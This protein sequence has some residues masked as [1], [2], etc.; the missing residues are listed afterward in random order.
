MLYS[1]VQAVA[2]AATSLIVEPPWK[3]RKPNPPPQSF[4]SLPDVI[5]LNCLARVSMS[6]YPKLSLVSKTFHSLILSIE[7]NH[8]RFH[9]Q[10]QEEIFSICLQFHD[11]PIPTWYTLWIK[12]G[13]QEN[14]RS[15]FVQV[16]SSY[17]SYGPLYICT[18]GSDKY[19]LRQSYPP[20][21][22]MLVRNKER[23]EWR[24]SP[25]MTVP[26]AY[27]AACELDGKIYVMGGCNDGNKSVKE[28]CWGEVFD[29]NTQTWEPLPNP[30]A[31]L[32]FSSVIKNIEISEGKLYVRSNE[33]KDSVYDPIKR[34][35]NVAEKKVEGES[36]CKV[37]DIHYSC[38]RK[39]CMWYDTESDEWRPV[40]GLSS[41]N[42][43][44]RRGLIETGEYCGKLLII[45]DK[46]ALPRRNLQKSICCALVSFEN[47]QDGEVW[48][49]VEW[50]NVVL[51]VPSSYSYL[52]SL[53]NCF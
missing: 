26:R 46:F 15:V 3:N 34:K 33:G 40:R 24:D 10:T 25:N 38:R 12:P 44:C 9:H 20:S 47:R 5:I 29:T 22:S 52:R 6:Y 30:T 11:R 21:P 17:D 48:G 14:K 27:P 19:A 1:W 2:S 50:S 37:G 31:E 45:W 13:E 7:L 28:S 43:S 18:V 8:A 32:R 16:P 51:T 4:L 23:V 42:K 53:A 41:L 49:K 39:S 35:W 36:R